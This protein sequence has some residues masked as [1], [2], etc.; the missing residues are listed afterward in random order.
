MLATRDLRHLRECVDEPEVIAALRDADLEAG[1]AV[2][3]H[4]RER[5]R[6][7]AL[8]RLQFVRH[9]DAVAVV[10]DGDDERDLQDARG[11]HRLPEEALARPGVAARAEAD[12]VAVVREAARGLAQARRDAVELRG[13]RE[14]DRARHLRR[15]RRDVRRALPGRE[16]VAPTPLRVHGACAVVVRHLTAARVRLAID[17]GVGVELREVVLER[18]DA[19][20]HRERLVAVIAAPPVT[21]PEG[22][23]HPEVRDL[24]AVTEDAERRPTVQ[25]LAPTD[26]GRGAAQHGEAVVGNDLVS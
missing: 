5:L 12:L 4:A 22:V 11:V 19:D 14:P 18:R 2:A 13:P 10:P 20:R 24:L 1:T 6:D 3:L 25:H 16:E 21:R 9:R 15:H 17:V 7:R 8:R 26:L 23:R